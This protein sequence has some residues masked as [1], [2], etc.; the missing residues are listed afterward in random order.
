MKDEGGE[1]EIKIEKGK[2]KEEENNE[3][4]KKIEVTMEELEKL[5]EFYASNANLP[6]S[7]RSSIMSTKIENICQDLFRKDYKI[8][9]INNQKGRYCESYPAKI[10]WVKRNEK[11]KEEKQK[12]DTLL[13]KDTVQIAR[14]RGRF[15]VPVIYGDNFTLCRSA[16]YSEASEIRVKKKSFYIFPS[17]MDNEIYSL[18]QKDLELIKLL[19]IKHI[20]D[21]MNQNVFQ[22]IGGISLCACELSYEKLAK[23]FQN[24]DLKISKV[25]YPGVEYFQLM[26]NENFFTKYFA[27]DDTEKK[28]WVNVKKG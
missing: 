7:Q 8:S 2:E 24:N 28:T 13:K 5:I 25:P 15:V 12:F 17:S 14:A 27:K 10:I 19:K 6:S 11:S 1:E 22:G 18:R 23:E 26:N 20:W 16:G 21:M 3:D 9:C 4:R